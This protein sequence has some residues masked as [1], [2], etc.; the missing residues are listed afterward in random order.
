ML[1]L[2]EFVAVGADPECALVEV[3]GLECKIFL[4]LHLLIPFDLFLESLDLF[5]FLANLI[6]EFNASDFLILVDF[7]FVLFDLLG[8]FFDLR[9]QALHFLFQQVESI[10]IGLFW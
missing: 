9:I 5:F 10:L 7:L 6:G 2:L 1:N 4:L 3:H 8:D